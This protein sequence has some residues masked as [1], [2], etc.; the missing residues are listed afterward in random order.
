[1]KRLARFVAY[2]VAVVV[3]LA[4]LLFVASETGEVVVLTSV[5]AGGE[6]HETR[7]WIVDI[8]DETYLRAGTAE[9]AWLERVLARPQVM[10]ERDGEEREVR[11]VVAEDMTAT[12]NAHMAYKYGVAD[13][14]VGA[15][16]SRSNAVA[17]RVVGRSSARGTPLALPR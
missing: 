2:A 12:V 11:L 8:E 15:L 4:A 13:M 7:V 1:M 3:V 16:L 9:S 6:F 17:L 5:D 14:L 10:L